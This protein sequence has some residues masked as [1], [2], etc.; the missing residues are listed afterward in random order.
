MTMMQDGV[1]V[2]CPPDTAVCTLIAKH[3]WDIDDCPCGE[4]VCVGDC[5]YYY[6]RWLNEEAIT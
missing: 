3:P 1:E 5:L 6:E 4:T 2:Q